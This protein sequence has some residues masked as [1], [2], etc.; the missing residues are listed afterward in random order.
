MQS[1]R[2][3]Y[4]SVISRSSITGNENSTTTKC[5]DR[6]QVSLRVGRNLFFLEMKN[7][8]TTHSRDSRS[9]ISPLAKVSSSC[10]A[11]LLACTRSFALGST[12]TCNDIPPLNDLIASFVLPDTYRQYRQNGHPAPA[13]PTTQPVRFLLY[14]QFPPKKQLRCAKPTIWRRTKEYQANK[15]LYTA[16]TPAPTKSASSRPPAAASDS[17]TSRSAAQPR[18]AVT[19]APSSQAYVHKTSP[20]LLL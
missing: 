10:I 13:I 19:A 14:P 12:A 16:T 11:K 8:G 18:N 20:L 6:K 17:C 1:S 5:T 9:P 2:I 3:A 7:C 4:A 15:N